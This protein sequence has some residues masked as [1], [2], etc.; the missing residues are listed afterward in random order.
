MPESSTKLCTTT[1]GRFF[2][3]MFLRGTTISDCTS[4]LYTK[5]D[6]LASHF[7]SKQT[8]RMASLY[9]TDIFW[10]RSH[11]RSGRNASTYQPTHQCVL[12][13]V[14]PWEYLQLKNLDSWWLEQSW[15]NQPT[16][17]WFALAKRLVI[18]YFK[19]FLRMSPSD[20][21]LENCGFLVM[22][23][24]SP[25]IREPQPHHL[26]KWSKYFFIFIISKLISRWLPSWDVRVFLLTW[27]NLDGTTWI[28]P[29]TQYASGKWIFR[30][31]SNPKISCHPG[32]DN[33]N[34]GWRGGI[35]IHGGPAFFCSGRS[36]VPVSR[37][38][39]VRNAWA[40]CPTTRRK[41]AGRSPM[42]SSVVDVQIKSKKFGP[43]RGDWERYTHI[44]KVY[45]GCL[46]SF[47]W[48]G[49]S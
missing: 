15:T 25:L 7:H 32:G 21:A 30:S 47:W 19:L 9:V 17:Q 43:P 11:E 33:K 34:P 31:G 8:I 24:A 46:F 45:W 22:K 6:F 40:R 44:R 20:S 39:G 38:F 36:L 10:P 1:R 13:Q 16:N 42:V 28:N 29:P 27:Y 26:F 48:W 5:L 2:L 12:D 3:Y 49:V 18:C 37:R 14:P 4:F 41:A 23:Q 35:Y